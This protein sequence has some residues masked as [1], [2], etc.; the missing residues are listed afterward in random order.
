MVEKLKT[1]FKYHGRLYKH[2]YTVAFITMIVYSVMFFFAYPMLLEPLV[3]VVWVFA[4]VQ[5]ALLGNALYA[6]IKDLFVTA[7]FTIFCLLIAQTMKSTALV[8]FCVLSKSPW[9]RMAL[10]VVIALLTIILLVIRYVM[11]DSVI[12]NSRKSIAGGGKDDTNGRDT[13]G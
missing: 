1:Y 6:N 13:N 7:K 12:T 11:I 9:D 2:L 10:I 4:V 8:I 3:G 5:L